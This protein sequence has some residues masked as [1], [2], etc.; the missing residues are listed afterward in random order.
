MSE[1]KTKLKIRPMPGGVRYVFWCP[2]C[3]ETHSYDVKWD[4][5]AWKFNGD[6]DKP[7]FTPSLKYDKCHLFVKD[8]VIEYCND[9]RHHLNN[10]D[11]P[12]EP[13]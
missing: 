12:L 9:C 10:K 8:G 6:M 3:Q 5:S 2:G 1:E 13:F 11:V 4:G 7:S